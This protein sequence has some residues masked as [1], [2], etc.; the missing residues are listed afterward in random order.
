M[1]NES[2]NYNK[3]NKTNKEYFLKMKR[4]LRFQSEV[5]LSDLNFICFE[6]SK[7]KLE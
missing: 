4:F 2:E 1:N 3:K 5:L 7:D 6:K